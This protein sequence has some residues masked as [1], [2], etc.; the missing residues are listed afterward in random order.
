MVCKIHLKFY[1][2]IKA[3]SYVFVQVDLQ[4]IDIFLNH[5]QTTFMTIP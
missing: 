3:S 1:F 2:K 4:K 5:L